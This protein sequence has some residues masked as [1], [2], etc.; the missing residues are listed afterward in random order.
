MKW[1]FIG[2]NNFKLNPPDGQTKLHVGFLARRGQKMMPD[3]SETEMQ[4]QQN[5]MYFVLVG[6]FG[7][8]GI[9]EMGKMAEICRSGVIVKST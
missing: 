4:F 1:Y 8:S 5:S 7:K 9:F 2:N 6:R 3:R